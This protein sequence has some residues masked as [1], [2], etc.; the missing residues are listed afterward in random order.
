MLHRHYRYLD[1]IEK[2]ER[3]ESE[4]PSARNIFALKWNEMKKQ[5]IPYKKIHFLMLY[6]RALFTSNDFNGKL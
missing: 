3:C 1:R 4:Q 2:C 5:Q 6:K